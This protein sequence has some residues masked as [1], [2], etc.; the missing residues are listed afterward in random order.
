M[1]SSE[2]STGPYFTNPLQAGMTVTIGNH[3]LIF[4]CLAV[5]LNLI[6]IEPGYYEDNKFGIRIEN[7]VIVKANP[8]PN[9]TNKPFFAFEIF[10]LVPI[11]SNLIDANLLDDAQLT[12]INNYNLTCKNALSPLISDETVLLYL[13]SITTPLEKQKV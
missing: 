8:I 13:D 1:S 10:T 2:R 3:F 9:P 11:Q 4:S 5:H 6:L 12:W 7:D